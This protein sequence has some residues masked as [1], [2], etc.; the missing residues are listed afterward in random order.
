MRICER[1]IETTCTHLKKIKIESLGPILPVGSVHQSFPAGEDL[2]HPPP[3]F[4]PREFWVGAASSEQPPR[5]KSTHGLN[6]LSGLMNT[7]CAWRSF[8]CLSKSR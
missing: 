7:R 4:E 2:T 1:E 3:R 8:R 5:Q 6:D